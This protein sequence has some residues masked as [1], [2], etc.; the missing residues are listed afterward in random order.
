M[1]MDTLIPISRVEYTLALL[2]TGTGASVGR[3]YKSRSFV[4][5]SLIHR[6]IKKKKNI[7]SVF[8][9]GISVQW[10]EIRNQLCLLIF[11]FTEARDC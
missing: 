2:M 10:E 9:M 1:S 7:L 6:R 4:S 3:I 8:A 5:I 11:C